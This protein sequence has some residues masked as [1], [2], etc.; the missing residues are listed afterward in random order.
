MAEEGAEEDVQEEESERDDKKETRSKDPEE[1]R[2]TPLCIS[3]I[4]PHPEENDI[5]SWEQANHT[6]CMEYG[7]CLE[8]FKR[9]SH[10]AYI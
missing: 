3:C 4:H 1:I 7:D 5:F 8:S 9:I 10:E 6:V 2:N